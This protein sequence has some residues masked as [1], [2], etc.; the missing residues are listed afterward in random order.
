MSFLVTGMCGVLLVL[1]KLCCAHSKSPSKL[2]SCSLAQAL[3]LVT[4]HL[5]IIQYLH[6]LAHRLF[7]DGL[8]N[9][10][11]ELAAHLALFALFGSLFENLIVTG[12]LEYGDTMLLLEH[13][14]FASYTHALGEFL[15][16]AVVTL[17][18]LFS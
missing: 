16:D 18:D 6:L 10:L 7:V 3:S 11:Q 1:L 5:S 14:D 9:L 8:E 12:V 13:T 17:V 4:C 2:T 15:Y